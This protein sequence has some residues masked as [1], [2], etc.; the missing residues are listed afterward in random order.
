MGAHRWRWWANQRLSTKARERLRNG[1]R[2]EGALQE[3]EYTVCGLIKEVRGYDKN[4][5]E[6]H[7]AFN[8]ESLR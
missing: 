5:R 2:G 7:R 1:G 6:S 3:L 8:T 4:T